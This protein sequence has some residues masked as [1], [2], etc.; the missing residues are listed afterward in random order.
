MR[1]LLLFSL[2]FVGC[3]NTTS[4]NSNVFE[5][6]F[7]RNIALVPQAKSI[8]P[9]SSKFIINKE[10]VLLV[11]PQFQQEGAYLRKLLKAS[12]GFDL[13]IV[14]AATNNF[15]QLEPLKAKEALIPESYLLEIDSNHINLYGADAAGIFRGIQSIR[16]L[17][18]SS[19]HTQE[20][21]AAWALPTVKIDD[22]PTFKWRGMLLDCCRH[23]FSKAVIKQYI[24]LLAYY[25]MNVLH[26]HLTEDQGWRIAIDKYPKLTEIGAWR[27]GEDG[28]PYGGFYSKEDIREIVAYA[29]ERHITIVPEIELP[30]HSQAAIAAYPHLSCTGE[31]LEVGTKWGVFKDV[32]C[33]G[34]DSTFKFLEDVL[35][36]V[37][38][39]F[40]GEYIHIGGDESPKY[41]WEN[42]SKCQKR[43]Q[44]E[45]L[46]DEH[47]LQSYFIKRIATFLEH[48][49]KKLIGWDEILEGGLAENAIVQ[50]WR[51][52]GGALEAAN[53]SH[54]AISSPTS[55]AYFDYKLDAIDLEK[56]YS[57]NPIPKDLAIDKHPFILGGECNIWTEHVP[58]A[59]V[60]DQK[61]F[62]RLLAMA[63][64][65]W[66]APK[67]KNYKEFYQRVQ[68]QY[69]SLEAFDVQYGAET[70]PISVEVFTSTESINVKLS[71]GSPDLDLYY[72]QDGTAPSTNS[73]KYETA[74]PIKK[75]TPLQ[76]QAFKNNKSYGEPIQRTFSKHLGN[77]LEPTLSY[78]YSSYYTGGGN[79]AVTNGARGSLNF[80]DGNWQAVQKVPMEIT[81]DLKKEQTI[82]R[83]ST[84]FFQKQDSWIFL[85]T[86]VDFFVSEDGQ[87]FKL[88]GS[89]KNSISPKKEASFIEPFMLELS[90]VARYVRMKAHNITYCP[91]WHA[92]AGSEAWLFVDEFVVE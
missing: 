17:L 64:V 45:Q 88:V 56:V 68:T 30:G 82:S 41:R 43:I 62:P 71:K 26:W 27:T 51:G 24:D 36:E 18:P 33:A 39:L 28:K 47:E 52:M 53:Q 92:A 65:L 3:T 72:T 50:S 19:F 25:K 1:L 15:I 80:R 55:H 34:N 70:M 67:K 40:P 6:P 42:C 29:Q 49:G 4:D 7:Q 84:A 73:S 48:K 16:Q 2:F 10:T 23:F 69:P 78:E 9:T 81:I 66:S 20:P 89:I 74:I 85:P 77:G 83:L 54:N 5:I 90:T 35:T 63:E 44:E 75:S 79:Q 86:K 59:V 14:N 87:N 46:K 32:Y 22:A 38:A 21:Q 11:P 91:D 58:N 12:M 60:L 8:T 61:V 37:I 57:F 31:Q 76:I 13:S